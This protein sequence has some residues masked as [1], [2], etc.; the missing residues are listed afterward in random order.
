MSHSLSTTEEEDEAEDA[1]A[2][3][4]S[5]DYFGQVGSQVRVQWIH[6]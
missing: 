6:C 3:A 2:T 1:V 4:G 5:F